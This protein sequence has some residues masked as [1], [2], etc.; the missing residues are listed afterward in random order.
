MNLRTVTTLVSLFAAAASFS[1]VGSHVSDADA[2]E[3]VH[4][5]DCQIETDYSGDYVV[6]IYGIQNQSGGVGARA[7]TVH[8][9]V[10]S[11][12]RLL[13][14]SFLI[15]SYDGNNEN[16][17]NGRVRAL[18]CVQPYNGAAIECAPQTEI[19][20]NTET[21]VYGRGLDSDDLAL[22]RNPAKSSWYATLNLTLP[23]AGVSGWSALYGYSA[24]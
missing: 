21:G 8:C 16:S 4:A 20:W 7:R 3:I 10:S 6:S 14:G 1:F 22:L 18:V 13:T 15:D 23:P 12:T 11:A 5:S 2:A 24:F 17:S 19:S 9:P